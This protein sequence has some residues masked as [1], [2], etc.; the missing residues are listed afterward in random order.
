MTENLSHLELTL[1]A[2]MDQ[3]KEREAKA[4]CFSLLNQDM[5]LQVTRWTLDCA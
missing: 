3:R 4:A 2:D 1:W 5:L